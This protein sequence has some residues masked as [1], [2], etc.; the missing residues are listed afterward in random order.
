MA[1][2]T[3]RTALRL[4]AGLMVG[5]AGCTTATTRRITVRF[6]NGFTGP[7]GTRALS[8]VR[9]FNAKNPDVEVRM[10]RIDWGTYYN[11]LFVAGIAGRAP[12]IFVLHTHSLRRFAEAGF[13]RPTDDLTARGFP[14]D[15]LDTNIRAATFINGQH[16]GLPIDIH[17]LGCFYNRT[18]L[19]QAGF[20]EPPQDRAG[21]LAAL[22]AITQGTGAGRIWGFAFSHPT[23]T[24]FSFMRQFG[25][26]FFTPD[27]ARCIINSPEN[28]DA[29]QFCVDLIRREKTVP[30]PES[31]DPWV[32]FRQGR[33]GMTYNG[34]YM[35]PDLQKQ[36]GLNFAGASVA[37]VGKT[38]AT[39]ASSH[40]FCLKTGM[41]ARHEEAAWRFC[42]FYSDNSLEWAEAGQVPARHSLR[43]S[44]QF[45]AMAVQSAF[46]AQ[47]PHAVYQPQVAF[48]FE[49]QTELDYLVERTLRGTVSPQVALAEAER[50]I[51]TIIRRR[52]AERARQ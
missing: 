52:A 23:A 20:A 44:G 2:V 48:A 9:A 19:S 8:L 14:V 40:N 16:Y 21:F 34:I 13:V 38:P 3:R 45:K 32:A 22:R 39:W 24:A 25:G 26:A 11:K 36:V 47:I 17:P 15:D 28:A 30:P 29:L 10:Q 18:L 27:A 7:D 50:K 42:K 37:T 33:V 35:L 41:D 31:T 46:A 49:F 6:W 5:A 43:A 12:E 4:G 1:R 51:N